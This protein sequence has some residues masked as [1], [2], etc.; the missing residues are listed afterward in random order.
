MKKIEIAPAVEAPPSYDVIIEP[1]ALSR[2]PRL[3]PEIA[4][5]HHYLIIA[6]E[7]LAKHYGARLEGSIRGTGLQV[8]IH[9]FTPGED[10][11][12]RTTWAR[13]TDSC[14]A[15]G[16][17]RDSAVIAL[18]GGVTGDLAGFVAATLFRGVPIIQIPTSLLAM[19]DSAVGGK[20]GVDT[21][22]GKNLVGAFHSPHLVL[23][24]PLVLRTLPHPEL[25]AGTAEAV[26]HG[27][28]ADPTYFEWISD[29]SAKILAIE[30][31]TIAHLVE[32]SI[33]IKAEFV[34]LDPFERG[35]RQAL[36][37][38]HTIGHAIETLSDYQ[39]LHGFAISRGMIL[40]VELGAAVGVTR[41]GTREVLQG[42]LNQLELPTT[43][44]PGSEPERII[45]LMKTDK[46]A[47]GGETRYTLIA[48]IGEVARGNDGAWSHPIDDATVLETLALSIDE[49]EV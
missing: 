18:G 20:T 10:Q 21:R 37:F 36:N 8:S 5:A 30:P 12:T 13:L 49:N 31:E 47:R 23:I 48:D 9:T 44:P 1:D 3:L 35:P 28:I 7:N 24:D 41:E 25:R 42:V 34:S 4:P 6:D 43:L 29:S 11:K 16:A 26:K 32:R 17:G 22:A 39:I 2:L 40:E 46:K 33:E 14:I 38:G 15:S 27:A 45:E 19:L